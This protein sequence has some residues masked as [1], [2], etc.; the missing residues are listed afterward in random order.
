MMRSSWAPYLSAYSASNSRKV[1]SASGLGA[2]PGATVVVL[3]QA[4][5]QSR[6]RR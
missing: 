6:S 2:V 5:S 4:R 3:A 1:A